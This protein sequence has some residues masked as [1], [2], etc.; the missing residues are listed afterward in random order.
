[1]EHVIECSGYNILTHAV[2]KA[3]G[4]VLYAGDRAYYDFE[5]GVWCTVLGHNHP[6]INKIMKEQ[7]EKITHVG[8]RYPNPVVEKAAHN[9]LK[10]MN[11]EHGKCVFLSSGSEAVNIGLEIAKKIANKPLFLS[12][13]DTFL[14]SYGTGSDQDNS[15]WFHVDISRCKSCDEKQCH[16]ACPLIK[17]IPIQQIGAFV[18]EP[19]NASG[20]IEIPPYK[21]INHLCHLLK[22]QKGLILVDEVTTGIG[23][24]GKWYG[25]M[26]YDMCPDMVAVGKGLG[27]GYPVSALVV[28]NEVYKDMEALDFHYAQSHQNDPLG[29]AILDGVINT[30]RANHIINASKIKGEHFLKKL[31]ELKMKHH[32]IEEVR[33]RGLMLGIGFSK[34]VEQRFLDTIH[35]DMFKEGFLIGYKRVARL[36]RFYPPLII[37][38]EVIDAMVNAL[39]RLIANSG[40]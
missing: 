13:K 19:G 28:S 6:E 22:Q 21:V 32:V 40:L 39:D 7:L 33:G 5:A 38:T 15:E 35:T 14:S 8:Y 18:F 25:Y 2:T 37:E 1:M 30:V 17:E 26:H 29:C 16:S 24:T 31:Q 34:Q 11:M 20:I 36:F 12:I 3:I 23:R 10:T 27:N 4:S 9:L